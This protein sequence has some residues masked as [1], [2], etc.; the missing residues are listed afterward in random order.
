MTDMRFPPDFSTMEGPHVFVQWKGTNVCMDFYCECGKQSHFDVDF[1][2]AI[3]CPYCKRTW[4]TPHTVSVVA[5]PED[6]TGVVQE[7][8]EWGWDYE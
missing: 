6:Y 3:R 1:A 5:A 2:Y 7:S 8:T 4:I